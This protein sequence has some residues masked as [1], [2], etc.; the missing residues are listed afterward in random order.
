MS[1]IITGEKVVLDQFNL[2]DIDTDYLRF[3]NDPEVMR[4]SNQRFIKHTKESAQSYL[5]GFEG[6]TNLFFSIKKKGD[7]QRIGTFSAYVSSHHMTA[8]IGI[9]IFPN[10][11]GQGYGLD[12]WVSFMGWARIYLNLRKI[13]A[14]SMRE[15]VAM[16]K[17]MQKAGMSLEA[18]KKNQELLEGRPVDILYFAK[19]YDL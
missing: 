12:A 15:N 10:A 3:L 6:T 16:I 1:L 13:T 8:D 4:F 2:T 9:L 7:N 17:L 18:I 11:W 5:A 14:G 19:F